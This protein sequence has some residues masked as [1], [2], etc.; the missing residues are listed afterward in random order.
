MPL[1]VPPKQ[2]RPLLKPSP[3]CESSHITQSHGQP[4]IPWRVP[5]VAMSLS[6]A[7]SAILLDQATPLL[8]PITAGP[9]SDFNNI[10][11]ITVLTVFP[12]DRNLL[13]HGIITAPKNDTGASYTILLM[14]GTDVETS[15]FLEFIANVLVGN[16]IDYYDDDILNIGGTIPLPHLHEIMSASGTLVSKWRLQ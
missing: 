13:K 7:F 3:S 15:S 8:T 4:L 11:D 9:P 16:D 12:S 10:V 2:Y 14:G 6:T 1:K 5:P